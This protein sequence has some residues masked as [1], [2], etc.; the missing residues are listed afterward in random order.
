MLVSK[1]QA[2][3][4]GDS[5]YRADTEFSP[6]TQSH[7]S[8]EAGADESGTRAIAAPSSDRGTHSRDVVRAA[9][10]PMQGGLER[11]G[12]IWRERRECIDSERVRI[13]FC[14]I[15]HREIQV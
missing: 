2:H 7:L 13:L 1:V 11:P 12:Q 6:L 10:H 5:V 4:S 9:H 15:H 3:I 8:P 14:F